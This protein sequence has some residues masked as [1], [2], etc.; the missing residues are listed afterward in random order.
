MM[1]FIPES[2]SASTSQPSILPKPVSYTVGSGQFVLTKNASIF[3]A[4]NNV[5]ETDE[6]FN[7]GQALAKKLNA[8]TGYTISVVK[9]NQPTAGSIYLTTVGGNAALGNEGYDLI[10]TSNQVTLTANKPEGV[11]RGNQTLLQL[12]PAGIEKNTV[13]SGVQW[14]IPHSN[15]SDKPEYEYRGLM[16]DVARHFFTVDEVKR[17]IDLAS[18]YKINKFHMHLSDDQGWRIEIKSWPDLIEIGSKGQ[19]GGGPG[20]YYTQEQFKDIVSYAAERY[21]EV[22]P[23]IDMPGHTNAALASYGELNPDGKRK[24]M[25]T[26]TAVGYSTLMP[27]AEITYQFVE[28]VISEL[29]AISPS[30]YIHLGG[31]ESNATSA[32]DYDYFFGRVTAIA[33][34]YGKKVVG[35]D[36]SDTS[37]GATSDSVLQ[38]WTCS[39]ST[40]TAAKAK[41]M[42]VI[43]SPANA[44]LDM[45]Y[46][47][48]SPI[49]LQ[50]RGFVNTN[51]AYNWDPTDCIK[52]ANIYGVESTLWTETFVTQDHLDYMLYPK[53]LSNAEVGW[54]ARGDR[55]WDDFKERLI[56]HTPRLQNKGIKF[57]ADPIVWEL[58]IVQINSEWKM[59][60][61]TGTVVKDTSGYLNGTL[62]GG[63]KWTAGKQGNGVSFDG[64]S[65][66]INL[67]GQDIT[68]NWTAAVW[69]YGQ[70]N[71]TNNETLLSGTTSAIKINQYNKTGKVGITIYGTKDY[72]Y[73][74]SIPSNKWT[75]LTFVG[76]STGTA[77][78][79]NGVLKETIAAKMNGPMALVGA[80]KTG[81]SG[82]LTSYFRGSLD[83]LKIFNRALSAS[84]VVEL[85][86]S[87]AP[88]ASLTGPQSA[89]P[90]QS[91]DVK[92]G[93]SDVSPSEFGQMYAQDWTINY[94]SAKL[95]LDSITS[96][97]DKFQVID[98]KELAPGQIRIVAAN[99]AA[100]QGVTPQGDLFAFKFTVKAG[101]DVKTTIS[102][103]HIVIG[104]AQGKELEIAGATHEIQVSI[105]VD[106]SQLNVLIANAQAKHDAAVEGNEDGLYAAGS[107]AQL[108][109]AI[110][111]AKAVA[112]NSNA[113]QQQVDSAK[114]ALEEAVQ[115]FESKKIS[116]DV[117][118]DGQVSIGDLAIIAGAYGKEE[119]QAGWNKKADV[120]HDGKVDIIDLTI[121]AKA[122]LQ[123]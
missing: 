120:N 102:A 33:N 45:K 107:K 96:L 20:G 89:N 18:Q 76:T 2:A 6:L 60:E 94:D 101:T 36:P 119:G 69:V 118:G 62:V 112:D 50:W 5:G 44:Y 82:D 54:T 91:F 67:G 99:A 47:S 72:T 7:I 8:S 9:S 100:N 93:L 95:Q 11:F 46:Y 65:G 58:P 31:D 55:N 68:G 75:H 84:E 114:S 17:Q 111:T 64:S 28:D 19:V 35:W 77:L 43:V 109:T 23:E 116:A 48:D 80:E 1:S 83:E 78:Y 79:E 113:S 4:G 122:I 90:G 59:D 106:K 22:I 110:H 70:P 85:A 63:A 37:S 27:R 16:L 52:G 71:T 25:R 53:L 56:E 10:T 104:N 49:G 32:A 24:A 34:S 92:M 97:Q 81:G 12:L 21:I 30:P 108:Q 66:Y 42:K 13:V 39:A 98:Q 123:I 41:G 117:N 103:D 121:V 61:G 26:D 40:G 3:V 105:P 57:F 38:N 15:I 88:K 51:R 73:N 115:V 87:P 14:V 74:Y 29:A 86:K